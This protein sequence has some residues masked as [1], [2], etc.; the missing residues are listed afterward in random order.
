MKNVTAIV[1]SAGMVIVAAF[2]SGALLL[3]N[4]SSAEAPATSPAVPTEVVVE[5]VDASNQAD[6]VIDAH[7]AP[8]EDQTANV[9]PPSEYGAED[10]EYEHEHDDESDE[11]EDGEGDD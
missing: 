3:W 7:I 4:A 11:H 10:D 9:E 1:A 5:F 2:G 6:A 8:A